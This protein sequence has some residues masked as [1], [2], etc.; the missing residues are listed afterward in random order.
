MVD[1]V[2]EI[3]IG[4]I[5]SNE[6]V[7]KIFNSLDNDLMD[8]K[9]LSIDMSNVTFI[10]VFFLER[11]EKFIQKAKELNVEVKMKNVYPSVYKVFHVARNKDIL[12]VVG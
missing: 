2:N 3:L 7:D 10:S 8:G 5:A 11:L 6:V 1:N 4:E 9:K 12:S